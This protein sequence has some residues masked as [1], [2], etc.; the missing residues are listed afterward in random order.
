MEPTPPAQ[1]PIDLATLATTPAAQ[2]HALGMGEA[3]AAARLSSFRLHGTLNLTFSGPGQSVSLTEDRLV[4]QSAAG[5]LHLR[6]LENTGAGLE[7]VAAK[8]R[9]YGRS[10]YGPYVER[11]LTDELPRQRDEVFGALGSLYRASNLGWK[12]TPRELQT[13]GGRSCQRFEIARGTERPTEQEEAFNGRLDPDSQRHFEFLYG[14]ALDSAQGS[15]CLDSQ[16][17][18]P[19]SAKV[20]LHWTARGDGGVAKIEADLNEAFEKAGDAVAIEVPASPL[21]IPHRPR[22]QAAA[23]ERFGFLQRGDGGTLI[24]GNGASLPA[25]AADDE[26]EAPQG[27]AAPPALPPVPETM[28]PKPGTSAR[29]TPRKPSAK[30]AKPASKKSRPHGTK[31]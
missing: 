22:G 17:A 3:E 29:G 28:A 5:N 30:P 15:I 6:L 21:P 7:V 20:Q 10:R 1:I 12:L 24:A 14:R 4:E 9:L 27:P 31:N 2:D 13:V 8:G 23:L 18:V 19:L 26:A 25:A 11:E 16:T